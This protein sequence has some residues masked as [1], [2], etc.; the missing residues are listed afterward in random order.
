MLGKEI[1]PHIPRLPLLLLILA[2]VLTLGLDFYDYIA[3]AQ[4]AVSDP[5]TL[6]LLNLT[7]TESF[8]DLGFLI[9][10]YFLLNQSIRQQWQKTKEIE[11][12][13]DSKSEILSIVS[14]DL[15]SPLGV[16]MGFAQVMDERNQDP[17]NQRM[18]KRILANTQHTLNLINELISQSALDGGGLR[19]KKSPTNIAGLVSEVVDAQQIAATQKNISLV[20]R[21]PAQ[22]IA[23]V[24]SQKF[25][26]ILENLISNA[27]KYSP[28]G[29]AVDVTLADHGPTFKVSV[30]DEGPGLNEIERHKVFDK[31]SK[32][33]KRPTAG[34]FSTGLGLS[35]TK[36]LVE[37]QEGNIWV[38]SEGDGKGSTFHIEMPI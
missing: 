22:V 26:Q 17:E 34:E 25:R 38:E 32:V 14:H 6:H 24:D 8:V 12:I 21:N 36:R 27:I 4:H 10:I 11:A 31:F 19:V 1:K 23:P 33:K 15:R 7:I 18:I 30:R 29:R 37:L 2:V 5:R 35:I 13:S 3:T 20:N 16:I 28:Q 9:A